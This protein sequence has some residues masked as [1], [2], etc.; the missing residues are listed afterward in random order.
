MLQLQQ[1]PILNPLCRAGDLTHAAVE[2]TLD[3]YPTAPQ[4]EVHFLAKK[5]KTGVPWWLSRLRI[6]PC[7][8]CGSGYSCGAGLSPGPGILQA[9]G[10]VKEREAGREGDNTAGVY[11]SLTGQAQRFTVTENFLQ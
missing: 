3:P 8:C 4:Q 7:H 1:R 6:G 9:V 11:A 5:N 10:A 2:T